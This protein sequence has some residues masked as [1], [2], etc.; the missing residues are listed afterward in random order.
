MKPKKKE[1]DVDY[2]GEQRNLTIE[3]EKAISDFIKQNKAK[4]IKRS[5][6][7]AKMLNN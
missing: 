4:K 6:S 2:I 1:L 3:E 7:K 5:S